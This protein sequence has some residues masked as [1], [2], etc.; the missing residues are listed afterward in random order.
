ME[1]KNLKIEQVIPYKG[2]PRINDDAVD[3][4]AESIKQFG[5]K[6]PIVVDKDNVIIAGHTRY[7]AAKKLG[8]KEVPCVVATDLTDAQ[9]KAYR[10]ADNKTAELAYWDDELLDKELGNLGD[11]F[12]LRQLGFDIGDFNVETP[13]E[14]ESVE[15]DENEET[16]TTFEEKHKVARGFSITYEI[17]F[18]NEEQQKKWYAFIRAL[19]EK[20]PDEETIAD[21]LMLVIDE[22]GEHNVG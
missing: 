6:Q 20:Y 10:L 14:D 15:E 11:E 1:V 12:D 7:K 21:R 17:A 9:V 2:N 13:E 22:W 8:L 4:V 18:D 5:F 16:D 19:R 3:A